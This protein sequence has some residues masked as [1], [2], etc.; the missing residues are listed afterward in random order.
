MTK[1][2]DIAILFRKN[3]VGM[4]LA[5]MAA[6][7]GIIVD[8]IITGR[9]LGT[10]SMAA[11]GLV[12]PIVNLIMVFSGVLSSGSQIVCAQRLGAGDKAAARRVFSVCMAA[13]LVLSIILMAALAFFRDGICVLLGAVGESAVLLQPASEY[14]L[15]MLFSIPAV[16]LLFEFNGLMRLDNDPNRIIAAVVTMT[17]L[18]I[19]GDLLNVFVIGGGMF[20]MGMATSVSYT[21]AMII[22]LFH[23]CRKDAVFKPSLRGLKWRDLGEILLAGSSSAVGSGAALLRNRALNGIMLASASAVAA[24]AALSVLNTVLNVTSC[25]MVG[26]GLTC[27]M[28]AGMALGSRDTLAAEALVKVAIKSALIVGGILFLLLFPFAPFI[29]GFFGD[30]QSAEM[31]QLATR[32]MRI[33]SIGLVLYALNTSFINYAQGMRRIAISNVVCFLEN[34]V[35]IVLTALALFGVLDTDAVWVGYVAAEVLT[36]LTV[37][38]IVGVK[39]RGFPNKAADYVLMK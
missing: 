13:T 1:R 4:I 18:D 34:F 9:F 37:L 24:T 30:G 35:W 14:L 22:M 6:M 32:G 26:V 17:V 28:L 36:F 31:V 29:A 12:T 27:S 3:A 38:G 11:Y 10:Q 15:G 25:T 33:Y 8:G 21:I 19:A 23:F 2:D 5:A 7:L 39:K 16:L 20:G